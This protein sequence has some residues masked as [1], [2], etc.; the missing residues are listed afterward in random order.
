MILVDKA[1]VLLENAAAVYLKRKCGDEI[2]YYK[3]TQ[4]G[5]DIDFYLPDEKCAI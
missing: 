1:S 5:I 3:S 2:Y 4:T